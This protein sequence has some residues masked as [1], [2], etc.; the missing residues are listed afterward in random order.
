MYAA[1]EFMQGGVTGTAGQNLGNCLG[2][3][4]LLPHNQR[5]V[6]LSPL[7]P[8]IPHSLPLSLL[9]GFKDENGVLPRD[10]IRKQFNGSLFY[11]YA[12]KMGK[13]M[14]EKKGHG[15]HLQ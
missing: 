9:S 8:S 7:L 13:S 4:S 1:W 14:K 15:K 11:E 5:C 12:A 3:I 10:A 6:H 2:S